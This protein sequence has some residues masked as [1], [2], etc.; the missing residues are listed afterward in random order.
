[1]TY[2]SD[3]KSTIEKTNFFLPLGWSTKVVCIDL[4]TNNITFF[5]VCIDLLINSITMGQLALPDDPLVLKSISNM[6]LVS[7]KFLKRVMC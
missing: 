7:G 6:R 2:I 4:G 5:A 3:K 1:L